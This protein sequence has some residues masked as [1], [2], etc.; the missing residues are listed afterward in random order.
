MPVN[1]I[2]EDD[3]LIVADKPPGLL[4]I[5]TPKA[6]SRTLTSILDE[7]VRSRGALAGAHP[8]HRLD[9]ETSGLIIY[10]KG[11]AA[12]KK[13]MGQFRANRVGKRYIAFVHGALDDASG[14]LKS[15]IRDR[16]DEKP[17]LAIT[18]YN[19]LKM[20]ND[21]TVVEIETATGRTNQIRIQFK[22]IGHPLVGERRF[23]FAKHYKLK[24]RRAALHASFL[25]FTHP[26]TG[27]KLRFNSP[28]PADME[29]FLRKNSG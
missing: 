23:A 9:R 25:E 17:R 15:Y 5:P 26:V 1:I 10:A 24:F 4:V 20:F 3:W 7:H 11:K 8:C 16:E 27:A 21:F 14:T 22:Q 13:I 28:M 12:Q 18:K 19:A 6:E 2:F 29:E